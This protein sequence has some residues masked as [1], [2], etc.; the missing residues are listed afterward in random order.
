MDTIL[1]TFQRISKRLFA[2]LI[3]FVQSIEKNK[4]EIHDNFVHKIGLVPIIFIMK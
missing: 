1:F 4:L 2:D 3:I